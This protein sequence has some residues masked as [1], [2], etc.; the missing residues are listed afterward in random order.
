M[1]VDYSQILHVRQRCRE[2]EG[3]WLAQVSL[4]SSFGYLAP[5]PED[6]T[7]FICP[8]PWV[9]WVILR[10]EQ[11]RL[12]HDL[13]SVESLAGSQ[14]TKVGVMGLVPETWVLIS[15]RLHYF[16]HVSMHVCLYACTVIY[17]GLRVPDTA[18]LRPNVWTPWRPQ[19]V[20]YLLKR[21]QLK[22]WR[23]LNE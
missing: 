21:V 3:N 18:D 20:L 6:S 13:W 17:V 22:M 15:G 19:P 23:W 8:D 4:R 1:K 11:A 16:D 9:D 2:S 5:V 7:Y 14:M 10:S 12:P